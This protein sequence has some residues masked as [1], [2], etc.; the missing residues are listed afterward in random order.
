MH[1]GLPM[2]KR[3]SNMASMMPTRR[4]TLDAIPHGFRPVFQDWCGDETSFPCEI[5]EAALAHKIGNAVECGYRRS[6]EPEKWRI[7]MGAWDGFVFAI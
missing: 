1:P 6:D 3:L 7:L 2:M 5:Y 4:M